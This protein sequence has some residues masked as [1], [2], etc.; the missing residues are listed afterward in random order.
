MRSNEL[1]CDPAYFATAFGIWHACSVDTWE[2]DAKAHACRV[3]N[4]RSRKLHELRELRELREK[5]LN[6]LPEGL[7]CS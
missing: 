6:G 2:E 4:L 1:P 7:R 3:Y 5:A